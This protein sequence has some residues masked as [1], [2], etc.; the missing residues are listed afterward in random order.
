MNLILSFRLELE[1]MTMGALC[2]FTSA[3]ISD[4]VF[5]FLATASCS[6]LLNVHVVWN[7]RLFSS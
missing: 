4:G 3:F 5:Y 1:S 2:V 6:L 7:S